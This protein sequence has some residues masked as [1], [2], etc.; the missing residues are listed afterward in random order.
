MDRWLLSQLN[1]LVQ[2]VRER[3]DEYD[4]MVASRAI[5]ACLSPWRP[6]R[7]MPPIRTMGMRISP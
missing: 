2:T 3:L 5:E 7:T 6:H 4:T 1:T